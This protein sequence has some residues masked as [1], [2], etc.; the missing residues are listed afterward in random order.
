MKQRSINCELFGEVYINENCINC[1]Y[2]D[3]YDLFKKELKCGH[4]IENEL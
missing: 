2:K 1:D 4:I 3:N